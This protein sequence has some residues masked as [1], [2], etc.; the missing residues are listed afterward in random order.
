MGKPGAYGFG[1]GKESLHKVDASTAIPIGLSVANL[2]HD[3]PLALESVIVQVLQKCVP[4][5]LGA[6]LDQACTR[7]ADM[8]DVHERV[9]GWA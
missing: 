6:A 9:R 4:C 2:A 7:Q 1:S 3:F 8:G 5:G